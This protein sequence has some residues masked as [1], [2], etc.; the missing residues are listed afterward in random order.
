MIKKTIKVQDENCN[1]V[2]IEVEEYPDIP[3]EVVTDEEAGVIEN[4]A[5]D[6]ETDVL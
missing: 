6:I 4:E 1:E 5:Q 2:E 3:V